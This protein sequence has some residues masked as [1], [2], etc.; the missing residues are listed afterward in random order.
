MRLRGWFRCATSAQVGKSKLSDYIFA[1]GLA[2]FII[3][4]RAVLEQIAPG[5]AYFVILL[6]VV[7]FA[8]ALLGTGPAVLTAGLGYLGIVFIFLRTTLLMW[9]PFNPIQV[10]SLIFFPACLAVIWATHALRTSI[11][12]R[13]M[14][15]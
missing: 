1:I 11:L 9:P 7:V 6:P 10:D 2:G 14:Q 5:I 8:G 4:C 13:I 15:P 12:A 3:F